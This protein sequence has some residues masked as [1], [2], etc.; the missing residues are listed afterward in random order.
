MNEALAIHWLLFVTGDLDER[1]EFKLAPEQLDRIVRESTGK[2]VD[3]VGTTAF[4]Q[5][6]PGPVWRD[7]VAKAEAESRPAETR[8]A[9]AEQVPV[10]L[11]LG[12]RCMAP[13]SL[14]SAS[15]NEHNEDAPLSLALLSF[16]LNMAIWMTHGEDLLDAAD[17]HRLLSAPAPIEFRVGELSVQKLGPGWY[18]LS[19]RLR[20]LAPP[21]WP[22]PPM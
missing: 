10:L 3:W 11:L 19:R 5:F 12:L 15:T 17:E 4:D 16:L 7:L 13:P 8:C 14:A 9:S 21:W 2:P 22:S 18:K 1:V 6:R 20:A